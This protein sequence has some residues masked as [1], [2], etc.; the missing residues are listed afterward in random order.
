MHHIVFTKKS[1]PKLLIPFLANVLFLCPL[2]KS[3]DQR[4]QLLVGGV[5]MEHWRLN[6][7]ELTINRLIE[8]KL[9]VAVI[10][11]LSQLI[12]LGNAQFETYE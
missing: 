4:F 1:S 12:I 7:K 9:A 10:Q 2:R 5:E 11:C 8:K 3:E 6:M